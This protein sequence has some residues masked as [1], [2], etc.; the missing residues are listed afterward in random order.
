M[1]EFVVQTA[2]QYYV[3]MATQYALQSIELQQDQQH[4]LPKEAT[5]NS[6]DVTVHLPGKYSLVV[7]NAVLQSIRDGNS[8][9][10]N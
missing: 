6:D 9:H 10:V 1:K 8:I 5:E 3:I 7:T 4:I 2:N